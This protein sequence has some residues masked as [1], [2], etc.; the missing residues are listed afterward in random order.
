MST[1][2]SA[3]TIAGEEDVVAVRRQAREVAALVGFDASD[4]TRIA[5]AV[6]EIARNAWLYAHGGQAEFFFD[7]DTA[8]YTVCVGD[9]GPGIGD[10]KAVLRGRPKAGGGLGLGIAG[11][12]R[13][14]DSFH[15]DSRPGAG[16]AVHL[17]KRLSVKNPRLSPQRLAKIASELAAAGPRNPM[18]ELRGQNAELLRVL[19]E[20]RARQDE[21]ARL[22]A[23]LEDTNRGVV[24]L[25]AELDEKAERLR[26]AD[27]TKSRFLSHISHEFR[28][29]LTSIMALSRLLVDESDGKLSAEQHKQATF[30]RKSAESLLEMVNDLLDLARMEA[31]KTVV[32]PAKFQ[33]A[34]FFGALR[35]VLRAL[36]VVEGVELVF[37]EPPGIPAMF[38]DE[39]KLSQILRNF[40]T[41][42]LKFTERGEVRVSARLSED[43]RCAIFTVADTGIGIQ[44][45]HLDLIFQE[46]AQIET[47]LQK[48]HRGVGLGLP[49]SKGLA[50]VLGGRLRVESTFG[51]GS[52]FS[53]EIPLVYVGEYAAEAPPDTRCDLLIVDDEE[54]IRYLIRQAVGPLLN[55]VEVSDGASAVDAARKL[56]PR[57]VLL[58]LRMPGMSGF[59]VLDELKSDP[60]TRDIPVAVITSKLVTPEDHGKLAGRVVA[61]FSKELLTQV[62]AG[63]KIRLVLEKALART[64]ETYRGA[65]A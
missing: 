37:E 33:V 57:A 26:R 27:Q 31:G 3:L 5:T 48:K 36:P 49:L 25:Y 18:E 22:N 42:A 58:D 45:D 4:Q 59:E 20:L 2:L 61:V 41:N 12:S 39:A 51:K 10:L 32:R 53:A 60:A 47:P 6:S 35:S 65:G 13:L 54:V 9:S 62:D 52:V 34:S 55:T 8:C 23:E 44:P 1:K 43:A 64:G 7:L 63:L 21:L 29:P 40:V 50:E 24:A 38:T 19:E 14:M 30:I 28:T 46:F 16:T 11:A 17:S 56:S 15:I